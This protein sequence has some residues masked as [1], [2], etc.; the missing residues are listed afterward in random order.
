MFVDAF[1]TI[2]FLTLHLSAWYLVLLMSE[3]VRSVRKVKYVGVFDNC[4]AVHFVRMV[5]QEVKH[6]RYHS[7]ETQCRK[8]QSLGC[9]IIVR[10]QYTKHRIYIQVDVKILVKRINCS[11]SHTSRLQTCTIVTVW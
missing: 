7:C 2:K 9:S 8:F 1:G 5:F 4:Q 6:V 3:N 11:R 10:M